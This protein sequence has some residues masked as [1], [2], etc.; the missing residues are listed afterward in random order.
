MLRLCVDLFINV[1]LFML[2]KVMHT[3][4]QVASS[5]TGYTL[6]PF[7]KLSV[8]SAKCMTGNKLLIPMEI[9]A[10]AHMLCIVCMFIKSNF[11]DSLRMD[12]GAA[13]DEFVYL[14]IVNDKWGQTSWHQPRMDDVVVV[15]GYLDTTRCD[16]EGKHHKVSQLSCAMLEISMHPIYICCTCSLGIAMTT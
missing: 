8:R 2:V 16:R 11:L 10:I 13:S 12:H 15:F 5:L 4:Y 9:R 6:S 7:P 1:Y 3:N 14:Q